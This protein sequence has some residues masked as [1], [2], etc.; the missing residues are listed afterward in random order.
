MLLICAQLPTCLLYSTVF[1]LDPVANKRTTSS[2]LNWLSW[3]DDT[4]LSSIWLVQPILIS[5][6]NY[7]YIRSII[8]PHYFLYEKTLFY[9]EVFDQSPPQNAQYLHKFHI[10]NMFWFFQSKSNEKIGFLVQNNIALDILH[11]FLS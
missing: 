6:M 7:S 1:K 10:F 4:W 11:M 3:I 5:F 2:H 8:V 9:V